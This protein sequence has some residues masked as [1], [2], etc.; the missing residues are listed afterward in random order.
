MLVLLSQLGGAETSFQQR[1]GQGTFGGTAG[2]SVLT[3]PLQLCVLWG[4][5]GSLATGPWLE[6]HPA[7]GNPKWERNLCSLDLLP[8]DLGCFCLTQAELILQFFTTHRS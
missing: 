7:G 8:W 2:S 3:L 6:A 5:T 1:E 4:W